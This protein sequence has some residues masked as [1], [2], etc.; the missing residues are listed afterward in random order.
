M[1]EFLLFM[2]YFTKLINYSKH[3]FR[4]VLIV[5]LNS[6]FNYL[7]HYFIILFHR[8]IGN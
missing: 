2:S 1:F 7:M 5:I 6:K 3:H 4:I 8:S